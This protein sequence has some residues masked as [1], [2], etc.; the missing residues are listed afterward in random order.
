MVL[1]LVQGWA[2]LSLGQTKQLL[3]ASHQNSWTSHLEHEAEAIAN[4]SSEVS[5]QERIHAFLDKK[6]A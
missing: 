1:L 6:R 4:L 5:V 3:W 2:Y